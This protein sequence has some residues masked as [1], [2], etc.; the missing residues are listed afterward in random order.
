MN[1]SFKGVENGGYKIYEPSEHITIAHAGDYVRNGGEIPE[2]YDMTMRRLALQVTGDDLNKFREELKKYPNDII[3]NGLRF[4]IVTLKK[5]S[6]GNISDIDR[7]IEKNQPKKTLF[8]LNSKQIEENDKNI[9]L[10]TKLHTIYKRLAEGEKLPI[11]KNYTQHYDCAA[12]LYQDVYITSPDIADYSIEEFT[13]ANNI[14]KGAQ[15]F[16]EAIGK[17]LTKL[18]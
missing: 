8:F 6:K 18:F 5:N 3:D 13:N 2:D 17:M 15:E 10:L 14:K 1:I 11:H 7:V 9:T 16:T 4:D 12:D